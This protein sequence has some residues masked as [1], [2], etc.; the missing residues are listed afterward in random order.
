MKAGF[1]ADSPAAVRALV[2]ADAGISIGDAPGARETIRNG[3]V[4]RLLPRWRLPEGGIYVVFP[5]GRHT[6]PT[7]RALIDFYRGFVGKA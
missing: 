2:E 7:V 5:P 4:R 3:G 6:P 1:R